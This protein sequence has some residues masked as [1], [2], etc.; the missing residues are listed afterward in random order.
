[1]IADAGRLTAT[2]ALDHAGEL[3]GKL[4]LDVTIS[5]WHLVIEVRP[6]DLPEAALR[7]RDD[8]KLSCRYLSCI[9]GVDYPDHMEALYLLRSMDHSVPI[10]VR[11][12]VDRKDPIVPSV[13]YIWNAAN[14][15]EREA[16][17]MFGIIFDGHPDLRRILT[18]EGFDTHPLRKDARPHRMRR[19]EWQWDG[20]QKSL[21]LPGEPDRR[22]RS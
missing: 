19:E 4:A 22:E 15:Q 21:R 2:E 1:M 8:E 9:I 10:H 13:T 12:K 16:Y 18:R 5:E 7:L 11:V 20:L 17:D 14:W 6:D 3:L